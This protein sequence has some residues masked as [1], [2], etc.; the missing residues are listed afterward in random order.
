MT[1]AIGA[2]AVV[3]VV[4]SSCA[5]APRTSACSPYGAT[6]A[7]PV[8]PSGRDIRPVRAA[9]GALGDAWHS[10]AFWLLFGS[11]FVCGLSTN[12]LIQTH[13]V[14]AAHDHII[15]ASTAAGYLALIGVFDVIG[16]IGSGWL[17]DRH[18]PRHLLVVY[19]VLRGLSL[20]VIDPALDMRGAGLLGFMVFYGLDWVATVPPTVALCIDQFGTA[21]PARL[22]LGLRRPPD[23]RGGRRMGRGRAARR[24]RVLPPG[25]RHLRRLLHRRRGMGHPHPPPPGPR[26]LARDGTGTLR[27]M[28][29]PI[30]DSPLSVSSREGVEID[31]CPQCRGVWLDRGELDKIID[32]AATAYSTPPPAP[33]YS[34]PDD[35]DRRDDRGRYRYDDRDATA[36]TIV[37]AS[38]RSAASS[39]TS[40]T[41]TRSRRRSADVA[42]DEGAHLVDR[43]HGL[44]RL[45]AAVEPLDAVLGVARRRTAGATAR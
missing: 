18:D 1:I 44:G 38:A 37:V 7:T 41:S 10:G 17:T 20:L 16:T 2:L 8:A 45:G 26:A 39:T 12:G 21:R 28:K 19:Y 5:T 4:V 42:A 15:S 22:R 34:P 27:R 31:F 29:C 32:R 24:H 35:R 13:F 9:F 25:V 36:T 11:F 43:R 33:A 14:S 3:P 6:E 23:G 30:D 40:S